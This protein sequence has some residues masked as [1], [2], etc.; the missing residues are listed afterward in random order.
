MLSSRETTSV[1]PPAIISPCLA[2]S[3]HSSDCP[4][5]PPAAAAAPDLTSAKFLPP[6]KLDAGERDGF[7]I[8]LPKGTKKDIAPV[9][10]DCLVYLY[11]IFFTD[12]FALT[13]LKGMGM[14]GLARLLAASQ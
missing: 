3:S 12:Q 2:S 7:C 6:R 4:R 8:V 11:V 1:H 9:Y 13:P 14:W 10:R 5:A